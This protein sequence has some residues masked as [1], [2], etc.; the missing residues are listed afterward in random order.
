MHHCHHIAPS[1]ESYDVFLMLEYV[2]IEHFLSVED[3]TDAAASKDGNVLIMPM[4]MDGRGQEEKGRGRGG[5]LRT[6]GIQ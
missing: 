3:C 6:S 5:C 4:L 1:I 2:R